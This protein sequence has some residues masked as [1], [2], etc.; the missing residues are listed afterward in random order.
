MLKE[1]YVW[2]V[3]KD[4]YVI[5]RDNFITEN[6]KF[7]YTIY[8]EEFKISH[9]KEKKES[10]CIL[11]SLPFESSWKE[12]IVSCVKFENIYCRP[13][14]SDIFYNQKIKIEVYINCDINEFK[15]LKENNIITDNSHQMSEGLKFIFVKN[16]KIII[17]DK[18]SEIYKYQDNIFKGS[19]IIDCKLL[20]RKE[21]LKNLI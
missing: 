8:N 12:I 19:K 9:F 15:Y 10:V 21:K 4:E 3:C 11:D 13:K 17:I 6:D 1:N 2:R 18:M 20:I 14:I 5:F 16:E 7:L